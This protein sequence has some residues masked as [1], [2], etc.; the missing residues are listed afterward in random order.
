MG[1]LGFKSLYVFRFKVEIARMGWV[2]GEKCWY[3]WVGL[4]SRIT[5][6]IHPNI[7]D[8]PGSLTNAY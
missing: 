8:P 7:K 2:C 6:C 4:Y 1:Q 5:M 3:G